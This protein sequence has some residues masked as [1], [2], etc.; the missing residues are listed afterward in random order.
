[1]MET[2]VQ[3]KPTDEWRK[4]PKEYALVPER[5]CD[6]LQERFSEPSGP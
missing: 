2:T 1:M 6:P 4:V 3:L 5:S